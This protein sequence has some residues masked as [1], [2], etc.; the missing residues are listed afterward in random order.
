[1]FSFLFQ[2]FGQK[3][4]DV[5]IKYVAKYGEY[6]GIY[7]SDI[8]IDFGKEAAQY[9]IDHYHE[10]CSEQTIRK[11]KRKFQGIMSS[12]TND[13]HIN[14]FR[15]FS[16]SS[17]LYVIQTQYFNNGT[18]CFAHCEYF[19][20]FKDFCLFLDNDLSGCDLSDAPLNDV[21][22]SEFK[23]D[24]STVLPLPKAFKTYEVKKEYHED[25]NYYKV[26]QFWL[27]SDDKILVQKSY[28]FHYFCDFVY[29]LD[30]DLTDA[31]LIMC[32]GAD[33]IKKLPNLKI[34]GI[35]VRSNIAEK[36]GIE[37]H[38]LS[39]KP[40][41]TL[42]S[43]VKKNEL[44]TIDTFLA[45]QENEHD[46]NDTCVGYVTDIH[47]SHRYSKNRCKTIED[48]IYVNR[49]I[50]SIIYDQRK[51]IVLIGGD[52]SE[53]VNDYKRFISTLKNINVTNTFL[54]LGNHEFWPFKGKT[55]EEAVKF[56][57]K[58]L[59]P[60]GMKLVHNNLYIGKRNFVIRFEEITSEELETI[61]DE[62]LK[63]RCRD[64]SLIIFG[65]MGFSGLNEKFNANNGIYDGAI[66][67][68][69]E[70]EESKRFHELYIKVT[71]CLRDRNVIVFTH[72]PLTDWANGDEYIDGFVYVS[73]HDHKNHFFDDGKRRI[74]ADN[75]IGY[76]G[77][78]MNLK[79]L[80]INGKYDWFSSYEDGIY[81]IE[82]EDYINFYRGLQMSLR[83]NRT[84]EKIYMLKREKTYLFLSQ[85]SDKLYLLNG[86]VS[87]RIYK[88]DIQ[89]F[90]DNMINY[91][92]SV[93]MFLSKY[94]SFQKE[95]SR[96][97]KDFGGD[98][99]IHGCIVDID[100]Y[101]HLYINPYDGTIVP[102]F[103]LSTVAKDVY[104]SLKRL[105]KEKNTLLYNNYIKMIEG[106]P[107]GSLVII[108][109]NLPNIRRKT[110]VRDTDMYS[111]SRII[112]NFQ[113]TSENNVIRAW[114]DSVIDRPSEKNG[115]EIV[116][117]MIET[118]SGK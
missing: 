41:Q 24:D 91:S 39:T 85:N 12:Y 63:K 13:C 7:F 98:G 52:L 23:T 59:A 99:R 36:L 93:N 27:G 106:E 40:I 51:E 11:R 30:G 95:I 58:L 2:K 111:V 74:Y 47:L 105:L 64:S 70:I 104:P 75:Q 31:D 49:K 28:K 21:D 114:N 73:G 4:K 92:K 19:L 29:F 100:Y 14:Q 76:T 107:D 90:Y 109:N 34:D 55:I 54:T 87:Q 79:T 71:R 115:K 50:A 60:N 33:V 15:Y 17:H 42:S 9:V 89:Y 116:L 56:Y 77:K 61:T 68:E 38:L 94:S 18:I 82:R 84:F 20:D 26:S 102:Y 8:L 81:Q 110:H 48:E 88:H 86:G 83:F 57:K 25:G 66:T 6:S 10:A 62:E 112:R 103:A 118:L 5:S 72:M 53:D 101:D 1:M 117:K 80:Y 108:E 45:K 46:E 22:F 67:R 78:D 44:T 113:Y 97:V 3:I 37:K 16:E 69:Q 43:E 65:G 32:N 35:K 96:K